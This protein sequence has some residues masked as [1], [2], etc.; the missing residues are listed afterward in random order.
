M[1]RLGQTQRAWALYTA[2]YSCS[3]IVCDRRQ[4]LLT[5]QAL[6]AMQQM[7]RMSRQSPVL[8]ALGPRERLADLP[9]SL[10]RHPQEAARVQG[11]TV[12]GKIAHSDKGK[13]QPRFVIFFVF[14]VMGCFVYCS[15]YRSIQNPD[16]A[17]AV[18]QHRKCHGRWSTGG[19]TCWLA[20]I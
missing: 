8:R 19:Q 13:G 15:M 16:I 7:I 12:Q 20:N 5:V 6:A 14:C 10:E 17:N 3:C 11:K 9:V 2:L 4:S 1:G 18:I